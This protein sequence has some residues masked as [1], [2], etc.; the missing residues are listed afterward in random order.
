[1]D[2]RDRQLHDAWRRSR[3]AR[4]REIFGPDRPAGEDYGSAD[5]RSQEE[6]SFSR[7]RDHGPHGRDDH[8]QDYDRGWSP[9]RDYSTFGFGHD[10]RGA[11]YDVD[12]SHDRHSELGG[13][14]P[15]VREGRGEGGRNWWDRTRD[16]VTSWFG[17]HDAQRRREWDAEMGEHGTR[18]KPRSE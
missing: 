13:Y 9:G 8:K 5:H 3:Q 11:E 6:R 15:N 12:Q 1:M 18:H 4:D 10:P 7:E 16:Q 2:E 17:D 14:T